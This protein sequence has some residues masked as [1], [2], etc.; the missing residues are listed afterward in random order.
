MH[1]PQADSTNFGGGE[2]PPP[3]LAG[4]GW[5]GGSIRHDPWEITP[6]PNPLPQEEGE[7]ILYPAPIPR[8]GNAVGFIPPR[9]PVTT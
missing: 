4:G 2:N 7:N 8:Y 3:P 1:R 6:P 5:G 9:P